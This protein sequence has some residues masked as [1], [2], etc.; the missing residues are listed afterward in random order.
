MTHKEELMETSKAFDDGS[1]YVK[2]YKGKT[3]EDNVKLMHVSSTLKNLSDILKSIEVEEP[4]NE[5][6]K[7]TVSE[8]P[9]EYGAQ[10]SVDLAVPAD[11]TTSN[12]VDESTI[13][14]I[15]GM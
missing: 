7:A 13:Q 3:K 5:A 9:A 1:Q 8:A 6:E 15:P 14:N 2:Q 4:Q 12:V 10:K 11:P